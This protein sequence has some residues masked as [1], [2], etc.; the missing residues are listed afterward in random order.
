MPVL[1]QEPLGFDVAYS[2]HAGEPG[3]HGGARKS[4]RS[5]AAMMACVI[6]TIAPASARAGD[7]V[8]GSNAVV[9]V[10][11]QTESDPI[12]AAFKPAY[13]QSSKLQ[14]AYPE[15]T[16][17]IVNVDWPS[18]SAGVQFIRRANTGSFEGMVPEVWISSFDFNGG[19]EKG[20]I[21]AA[22]WCQRG[23]AK[24]YP[25]I[26]QGVDRSVESRGIRH[27]IRR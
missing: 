15:A 2:D 19:S 26:C 7:W 27:L 21:E 4:I 1:D 5:A 9:N 20:V 12:P 8:V 22:R 17:W 10:S 14:K 16:Q 13:E 6:C 3:V 24:T 18:V 11:V 23:A 25:G